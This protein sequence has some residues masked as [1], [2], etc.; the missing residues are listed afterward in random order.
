M[1]AHY[2]MAEGFGLFGGEISAVVPAPRHRNTLG[3]RSGLAPFKKARAVGGSR[4]KTTER[5][6]AAEENDESAEQSSEAAEAEQKSD[7]AEDANN[8]SVL[9]QV[10]RIVMR[11]QQ[12]N[13]S[14]FPFP[15]EGD[16][17]GSP[18]EPNSWHPQHQLRDS[19]TDTASSQPHLQQQ[20]KTNGDSPDVQQRPARQRVLSTKAKERLEDG[21]GSEFSAVIGNKRSTP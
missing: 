5:D 17:D 12:Q 18:S 7:E 16:D 2:R 3:A 6:D 15:K 4:K 8:I 10:R 13:H 11:C 14:I 20:K 21:S 19:Q 1:T 9:H